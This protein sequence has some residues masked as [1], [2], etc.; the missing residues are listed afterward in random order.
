VKSSNPETP[1]KSLRREKKPVLVEEIKKKHERLVGGQEDPWNVIETV[2]DNKPAVINRF[3]LANVVFSEYM[4]ED[5]MKRGKCLEKDGLDLGL[6]TDQLLFEKVAAEYNK[7]GIYE[8][9]QLQYTY[10]TITGSN[11]PSNYTP[12]KWQDA[13]QAF[14]ECTRELQQCRQNQEQSGTNDSDAEEEDHAGLK[15]VPFT[16]KQ[17]VTYWNLF[18]EDN[19]EVFTKM[20]GDLEQHVQHESES[21]VTTISSAKKKKKKPKNEMVAAVD[22]STSVSEKHLAVVK[23]QAQAI[24]RSLQRHDLDEL[25]DRK[26]KLREN[27]NRIKRELSGAIP[28][29]QVLKRRMKSHKAKKEMKI[30]SSLDSTV[31]SSPDSAATL[32]SCSSLFDEFMD[33]D[34]DF[35]KISNEIKAME[36]IASNRNSAGDDNPSG[37]AEAPFS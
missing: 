20:V 33:V 10:V 37:D 15:I 22:R 30:H 3:R 4:K 27:L 35:N 28:D 13:K 8:Y 7:T 17:Y 6:R 12:I 23:W 36:E 31:P 2:V 16:N 18:A 26:M 34:D 32:D 9:D 21:S 19:Q 1:G 29:K 11:L 24:A 14:K 25:R 5:M